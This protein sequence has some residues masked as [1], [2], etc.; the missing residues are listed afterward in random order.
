MLNFHRAIATRRPSAALIISIIALISSLAGTAFAA[1]VLPANSVH[2]KQIKD[3][4]VTTPK[5]KHQ[6]V[7]GPKIK[8]NSINSA[9]VVNRSLL[10]VD[11]K[12]GE[13]PKGETGAPGT[14]LAYAQVTGGTTPSFVA[15][16]T[17]GFTK[18]THIALGEYCLTPV[19]GVS[20]AARPAVVSPQSPADEPTRVVGQLA[21]WQAD[22]AG[23]AAGDYKIRTYRIYVEAMGGPAL[24]DDVSFALIV[25]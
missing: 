7:T 6:A 11:F 3:W 10:A 15:T 8:S 21:L 13:L 9:K 19:A 14:A 5:I 25:A 20:P 22:A 16:A 2:T 18:V 1:G 12:A 24:S 23:C 17:K 4:A